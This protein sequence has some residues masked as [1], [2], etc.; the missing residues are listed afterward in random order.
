MRSL[1]SP[2]RQ[3]GVCARLDANPS[4]MGRT[5]S[6]TAAPADVRRCSFLCLFDLGRTLPRPLVQTPSPRPP[7]STPTSGLWRRPKLPQSASAPQQ[8]AQSYQCSLKTSRCKP[9]PS[10]VRSSDMPRRLRL[11]LVRDLHMEFVPSARAEHLIR[12]WNMRALTRPGCTHI[13]TTP[14]SRFGSRSK[15]GQESF[16]LNLGS[17]RSAATHCHS[18]GACH[19]LP[20]QSSAGCADCLDREDQEKAW[21]LWQSVV[22]F[23]H[24]PP[25]PRYGYG[26]LRYATRLVPRHG[27]GN[28]GPFGATIPRSSTYAG[29]LA[30]IPYSAED[31]GLGLEW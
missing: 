9:L 16:C 5:S 23:E 27:P 13:I 17:K 14:M 10:R 19:L 8:L 6:S 15:S 20:S 1:V 29:L 31:G 4:L 3:H 30:G 24:L 11:A 7:F 28:V 2:N 18:A 26:F 25:G 22:V 12:A 21:I